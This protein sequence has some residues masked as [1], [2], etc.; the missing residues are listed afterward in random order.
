MSFTKSKSLDKSVALEIVG[1]FLEK[2]EYC[3]NE[4]NNPTKGDLEPFLSKNFTILRNGKILAKNIDEYIRCIFSYRERFSH[5]EISNL[6]VDVL[7]S[8]Y[9]IIA[10]FTVSATSRKDNS[11]RHLEVIS[12]ASLEDHHFL[13]WEEVAGRLNEEQWD[14]E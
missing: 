6:Y 8:G 1:D 2:F 11:K 7:S 10:K 5:M 12:I 4:K 13:Q 3:C 14:K 9:Q